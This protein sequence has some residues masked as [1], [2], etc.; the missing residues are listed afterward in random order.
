MLG[1]TF[2]SLEQYFVWQ[3]ARYFEDLE[4][5]SEILTLDNPVS[6]K[7]LGN[8]VRNY[9]KEEWDL[10]RDKARFFKNFC[11]FRLQIMFTGLWA[12]FTQNT[13]LFNQLRDTGDGLITFA[14][15]SDPHWS[16][17]LSH[18]SPRLNDPS[19]WEGENK[20]RGREAIIYK[21]SKHLKDKMPYNYSPYVKENFEFLQRLS[22]TSS[23]KKKN[24]LVLSASADQIL[25]IVEIC[26]NILKNNF[27][28]S[29]RQRKKLA[30]FADFYRAI[31]RTRTEN[32]ARKRLQQGGANS[33]AALAAILVPVLGA[34]AEHIIHKFSQE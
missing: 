29:K 16:N 31:A 12:K 24:A 34:L 13:Q 19:L 30:Q 27:T 17:G 18:K 23:D 33:I 8:R 3:K 6:I 28:L 26:A 32:S 15:D 20:K 21:C 5:A 10:V 2:S 1:R 11:N 4:I 14:F 22:K 25:A 7:R 9:N